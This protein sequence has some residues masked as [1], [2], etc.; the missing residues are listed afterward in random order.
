MP[1]ERSDKSRFESRFGGGFIA[2]AQYLAESMVDRIARKNK[3]ILPHFFWKEKQWLKQFKL[4]LMFANKLLKLYSVES[5][6]KVLR[7]PNGKKI[8]SL[9]AKW[10]YEE[11]EKENDKLVKQKENLLKEVENK[12]EEVVIKKE[13]RPLFVAKKSSLT[14]LRELDE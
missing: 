8:Y 11:I 13:D 6:I 4:Q 7:T 12:Q 9:G 2:P 3:Q 1:E 5:I 10:I 14:K